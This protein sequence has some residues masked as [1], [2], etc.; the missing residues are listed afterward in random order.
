METK[1]HTE[2]IENSIRSEE[3]HEIMQRMPRKM[4]KWGSG[5]IVFLI[6]VVISLSTIIQ[7]PDTIS[8]SALLTTKKP[9]ISIISRNGGIIERIY[10]EDKIKVQTDEPLAVLK[11]RTDYLIVFWIDSILNMQKGLAIVTKNNS[12]LYDSVAPDALNYDFWLEYKHRFDHL[13]ELTL[14]FSSYINALKNF[15]EINEEKIPLSKVLNGNGN[16]KLYDRAWLIITQLERLKNAIAT[17]KDR[18]LLKA[19]TSGMVSFQTSR[20]ASQELK[21]GEEFCKILSDD[22]EVICQIIIPIAGAAKIK[23]G[24]K[25]RVVLTSYPENEF[26]FIEAIVMS[27]SVVP[28]VNETQSN[29]I[30]TAKVPNPLIT[31]TNKEISYL[32]E[33]Q[34]TAEI[35]TQKKTIFARLTDVFVNYWKKS[36]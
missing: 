30:I 18:N 22:D 32:P 1:I 6:L 17:W 20:I 14:P 4:I 27:M 2:D 34:G 3:V 13:G 5:G 31:S 12:L 28:T 16:N 15:R 24:Q 11:N 10:V 7:Y 21:V 25:V 36:K 8:G 33:M 35:I 19:P 23:Q 9:P 29:Y 26:G